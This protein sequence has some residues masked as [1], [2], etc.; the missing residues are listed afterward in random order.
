MVVDK[1]AISLS[2]VYSYYSKWYRQTHRYVTKTSFDCI[3]TGTVGKPKSKSLKIPFTW[4]LN[5]FSTPNIKKVMS[6]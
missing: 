1:E 5:F 3:Q 2:R 4:S 6:F